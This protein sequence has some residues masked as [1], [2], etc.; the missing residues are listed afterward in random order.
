TETFCA[1]KRST[2][3]E[4]E[5]STVDK[6]FCKSCREK[7]PRKQVT[8]KGPS[9]KSER[10]RT[11]RDYANL[12]SGVPSDPQRWLRMMEGKPIHEDRFK[13]MDGSDVGLEWVETDEKALTEPFVIEKP[14][15]LGMNM[16]EEP[17]A[18]EDVAL[19][20]GENTPLEV[21]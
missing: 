21:I 16:P 15:G 7:D 10:K 1:R 6:W 8:F 11:T 9:R 3:H 17:F 20:V 13:R 2:G 18:I 19:L 4:E 14:E 5:L 12:E